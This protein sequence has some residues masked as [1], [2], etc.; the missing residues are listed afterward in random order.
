MNPSEPPLPL[1]SEHDSQSTANNTVDTPTAS[2]IDS[3]IAIEPDSGRAEDISKPISPSL[4]S[5][6]STT[7][8]AF[9]DMTSAQQRQMVIVMSGMI[10]KVLW[11]SLKPFIIAGIISGAIYYSYQRSAIAHR[12]DNGNNS[13][14]SQ[15]AGSAQ[16]NDVPK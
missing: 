11:K 3:H 6:N 15:K 13:K 14:M 12:D 5:S 4:L 9:R 16:G 2:D 10:V 8:P 1:N 7:L